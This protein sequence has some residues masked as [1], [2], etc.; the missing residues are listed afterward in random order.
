[1]L[2]VV[3]NRMLGR[4]YR[5]ERDKVTAE[6]R[7]LHNEEFNDLYF[8]PSI[9]LVIKSRSRWARHVARMEERSGYRVW[10]GNLWERDRGV[11]GRINHLGWAMV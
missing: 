2:R 3:E 4:K 5:P 6:W 10:W 8:S 11:E 7:K 1:M 9:I